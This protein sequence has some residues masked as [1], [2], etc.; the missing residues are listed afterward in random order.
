MPDE[1]RAGVD[2]SIEGFPGGGECVGGK[3]MRSRCYTGEA[4]IVVTIG[5]RVSGNIGKGRRRVRTQ[6]QHPHPF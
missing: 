4:G 1:D 6:L 3:S 2:E 5:E